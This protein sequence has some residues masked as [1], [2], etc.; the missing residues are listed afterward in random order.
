MSHDGH[1]RGGNREV[2]ATATLLL[3]RI[4][5]LWGIP[6]TCTRST[7]SSPSVPEVS[8]RLVQRESDHLFHWS[9]VVFVTE[10]VRMG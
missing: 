9:V 8:L 10:I 1:P 7:P 4:Q 5:G 6:I 2:E 3:S